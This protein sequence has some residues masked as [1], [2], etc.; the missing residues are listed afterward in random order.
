[1]F[2]A[3]AVVMGLL[4]M[5]GWHA[6]GLVKDRAFGPPP[7]YSGAGD[8]GEHDRRRRQASAGSPPTS[9]TS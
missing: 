1:M 7:D 6:Y 8:S 3:F 9:A 4:G 2:I 5:G